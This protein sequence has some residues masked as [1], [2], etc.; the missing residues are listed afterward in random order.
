[1]GPHVTLGGDEAAR[2]GRG[3]EDARYP[4]DPAFEVRRD[5]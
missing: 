1:M 5:G 2:R 3:G 4:S